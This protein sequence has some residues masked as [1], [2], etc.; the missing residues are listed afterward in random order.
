MTSRVAV[1]LFAAALSAL[2]QTRKFGDLLWVWG[3]PQG[4]AA[5]DIGAGRMIET[6][7]PARFAQAN[8]VSKARIL[9]VSNVAMAGSGL[10]SDLREAKRLSREVGG[11]RRVAWEFG[12]DNGE[13]PPFVY[14][15]KVEI[16]RKLRAK[17]KHIEAVLIDDM[18][19]SQRKQGL[20]VEHIATL[21]QQLAASV[22]DIRMWGIV[23]TMN[24]KDPSLPGYLK[25]LDVV[26]LWT[27]RAEELRDLDA[28]FAEAEKLAG[29]KPIV[30]GLYLYDYGKNRQMPRGLMELQCEKALA[31]AKQGRVHGVI[32]LLVSNAA[33][34]VEWTR[35]WI[36]RVAG[37]P[38]PLPSR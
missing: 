30:L 20:R 1:C 28:N 13:G 33:E 12:P 38:V 26:N 29:G 5:Y 10:P 19:T 37:E 4:I 24:L 15:R 2:G 8:A 17:H 22:P 25:L 36:A 23:Y 3:I 9:G 32:F 7:E 14:T 11:L 31:L 35:A 27:W 6:N 18:L 16:L 21:R 34:T